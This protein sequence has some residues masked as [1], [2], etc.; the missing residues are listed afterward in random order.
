MRKQVEGERATDG[1]G[2]YAPVQLEF[3]ATQ[4]GLKTARV[5]L[6]LKCASTTVMASS[7][8]MPFAWLDLT[9]NQTSTNNSQASDHIDLVPNF[10][11]FVGKV[12]LMTQP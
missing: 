3:N 7:Q 8:A 6:S 4:I 2:F 1:L 11:A 5:K 10:E 12:V 9:S